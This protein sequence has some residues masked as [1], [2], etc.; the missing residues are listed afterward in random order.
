M[1]YQPLE[2]YGFIGD[3][4]TVALVGTDGSIDYM[5]FPH[6]DDPT[7]FGALLDDDK[8]GRFKIAPAAGGSRHKQMYL[9]DTN[10]LLTRFLSADGLAEITD[11]MPVEDMRHT[12]IL[13]RRVKAVRGTVDLRLECRP[14]FDYARAGHR[15][16]ARGDE[17]WFTPDGDEATTLR[18]RC[19]VPVDIVDGD[20]VAEFRLAPGETAD[21]IL[22]TVDARTQSPTEAADYAE[23]AFQHNLRY[24]RGWA[25]Q[26]SYRGRWLDMITRSAL[27]L[28]LLTS[29]R[30]GSIAAAGTFGLPEEI[31]GERN[32]DYR[33]TWIRDAS[34]TAASLV[35][36]GFTEEAGRFMRWIEERFDESEEPGKLQIMYGIDGRH[37]LTEETLE[38]LNG[39]RGSRPVRTGNGAYD[40]VQLDIYGE[41]LYAVDLYDTLVEPVSYDLWQDL[42][43]ATEWVCEHWHEADEGIWEVRGGQREFLYSRLTDWVAMDRAIRIAQRR[44]LPAP[45]GR[46][47][48]VRDD[49]HN[50]IYNGF[51]NEKKQ[52]FV[53][54]KEADTLDA[55]ALMMPLVDFIA[56]R[57]PR[58]LSTL[59][60]IE[61]ELVDD[62]LVYRYHPA[63]AAADGLEGAEGT[64]G[65]C[66]F[67]FVEC[68]ARS[69]QVD[70]ARLF[71]EKLHGYANHLGLYAEEMDPAG[72]FLGN[73][74][75]AFTHLALIN[76]ALYLNGALERQRR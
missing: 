37:D 75:Q 67:W 13:V 68:L 53:Q 60:A 2:D 43:A 28:K 57:D 34:F 14:R 4:H 55:S 38:H 1:A 46:W 42:H 7:V 41:L 12:H 52:A 61:D 66:S 36:L 51:W 16:E 10:V 30:Y 64:F 40:Q 73:Y 5:C 17:I 19:P 63:A 31:G 22:E 21:F 11:F 8:G 9:P 44:S 23:R 27:A 72:R 69:G 15:A 6:F 24:W 50:E 65:I 70:K 47:R 76:S 59:E 20:A 49:I 54:Y 58:W 29:D 35:R 25:S 33:F 45:L 32:W 18:L 74:P 39:Y 48:E 71:F 26:M 62:A 56:S 3:L